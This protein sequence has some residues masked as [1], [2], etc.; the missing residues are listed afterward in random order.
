MDFNLMN[1]NNVIW[2]NNVFDKLKGMC[3]QS[4]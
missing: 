4:H 2:L 3:F 1:S